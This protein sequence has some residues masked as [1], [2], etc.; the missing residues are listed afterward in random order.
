M[1]RPS[2]PAQIVDD[3]YRRRLAAEIEARGRGEQARLAVYLKCSPGTLSDIISGKTP[4]T[5]LLPKISRYFGWGQAP[6]A[7]AYIDLG[8]AGASLVESLRGADADLVG[9]IAL[10]V[11]RKDLVVAA[12]DL[13]APE[14]D[15]V[16]EYI[17]FLKSQ[18]VASALDEAPVLSPPRATPSQKKRGG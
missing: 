2:E 12:A 14:T 13:T 17:R 4:S 3:D 18:R 7:G 8:A 6:S 1:G 16:V 9:A 10:L 11:R 15:R 5:H